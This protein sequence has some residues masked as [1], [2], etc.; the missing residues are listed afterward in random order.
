MLCN[1]NWKN[2]LFKNNII[3]FNIPEEKDG[4]N[5]HRGGWETIKE[6]LANN[7]LYRKNNYSV[8]KVKF[9]F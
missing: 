5:E 3:Q 4:F 7:K 8:L 2:K 1:N 6:Y 9:N